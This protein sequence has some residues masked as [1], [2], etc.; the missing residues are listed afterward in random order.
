MKT[1]YKVSF[2]WYDTTTH[3]SNIVFA[4]DP[5]SVIDHYTEKGHAWVGDPIEA[6]TYDVKDAQR[7]GMPIVE[8]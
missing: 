5:Q 8:I 7:R 6:S 1:Y 3:C 4:E 2:R